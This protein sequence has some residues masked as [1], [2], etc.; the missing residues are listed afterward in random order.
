V[1]TR[2]EI[3]TRSAVLQRLESDVSAVTE[4]LAKSQVA[5]ETL[6]RAVREAEDLPTIA[7]YIGIKNAQQE[8]AIELASWRRKVDILEIAARQALGSTRA[9]ATT[10]LLPS[11]TSAFGSG[12]PA[13][14]G[15]ATAG[16]GSGSPK[17]HATLAF[18]GA[19]SPGVPPR[20]I[21]G[22]SGTMF[23]AR[24]GV[25]LSGSLQLGLPPAVRSRK[26]G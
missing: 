21:A 15:I 3:K 5:G 8:L 12:A 24:A 4:T 13:R 14:P 16:A 11:A 26:F 6:A 23:R 22:F 20:G 17:G 9:A 7:D 19:A 2:G 10:E 25:A 18:S 1:R